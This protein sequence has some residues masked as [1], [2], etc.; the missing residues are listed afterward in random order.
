[1]VKI[2]YNEEVKMSKEEV[3]MSTVLWNELPDGQKIKA[4]DDIYIIDEGS[5]NLSEEGEVYITGNQIENKILIA[6]TGDIGRW[7]EDD[8]M[9]YFSY[10]SEDDGEVNIIEN[11]IDF[12][13]NCACDLE[14]D[15]VVFELVN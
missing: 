8:Q 6:N 11:G 4:L 2:L 10:E 12:S 5:L 9:L 14:V 3:K 15:S 13:E 1:M 7:D